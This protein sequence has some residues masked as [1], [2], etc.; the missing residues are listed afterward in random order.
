MPRNGALS[1]GERPKE[2]HSEVYLN[3][4]THR[5]GLVPESS[6]TSAD[7]FLRDARTAHRRFA[8]SHQGNEVAP[9]PFLSQHVV[10]GTPGAFEPHRPPLSAPRGFRF[11]SLIPRLRHGKPQKTE[12]VDLSSSTEALRLPVIEAHSPTALRQQD[13]IQCD[14]S[15]ARNRS[16]RMNQW[17]DNMD[18]DLIEVQN[19]AENHY[20]AVQREKAR[21]RQS[22]ADYHFRSRRR[23][24]IDLEDCP[25]NLGFEETP[26]KES[27]PS[28]FSVMTEDVFGEDLAR[29]NFTKTESSMGSPSVLNTQ[30][31]LRDELLMVSGSSRHMLPVS[32]SVGSSVADHITEGFHS[33]AAGTKS[34]KGKIFTVGEGEHDEEMEVEKEKEEHEGTKTEKGRKVSPNKL[35]GDCRRG[36]QSVQQ[37][38]DDVTMADRITTITPSHAEK[39]ARRACKT[40][41]LWLNVPKERPSSTMMTA[42]EVSPV[43]PAPPNSAIDLSLLPESLHAGTLHR[44][45]IKSRGRSYPALPRRATQTNRFRRMNG[46]TRSYYN[47]ITETKAA[48]AD[49]SQACKENTEWSPGDDQPLMLTDN[50]AS[51][52]T[53]LKRYRRGSDRLRNGLQN[54]PGSRARGKR[55]VGRRSLG[56][57]TARGRDSLPSADIKRKP[58]PAC[59]L[60]RTMSKHG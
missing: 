43:C 54:G 35:M 52:E 49:P 44:A 3:R 47:V 4:A 24:F 7:D 51:R 60:R 57:N 59:G 37:T 21:I 22:F 32:S 45:L 50:S 12:Q 42:A 1:L 30:T 56:I 48:A 27:F 5:Y 41:E 15:D 17:L 46:F 36:N 20:D 13:V 9:Q 55:V 31:S 29:D 6:G 26:S 25:G 38:N 34:V 23:G 8:I 19:G 18:T 40:D 14:Y 10:C 53:E 2:H 28:P 16:E 39:Y 58:V 33:P 11:Q